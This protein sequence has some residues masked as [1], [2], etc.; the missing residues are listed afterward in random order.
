MSDFMSAMADVSRRRAA[1]TRH[2]LGE[3]ALSAAAGSARPVVPLDL[4]AEGFDLIAEVKLAS[5]SEGRLAAQGDDSTA[6]LGLSSALVGSG[7]AALS[8]LTEP[9]S[10]GGRLEH[11]EVVARRFPVPAMRKDFLVDPIQVLEARAAGASGVLLIARLLE[12]S[13]LSEMTDLSLSLGMF[14]LVELF[15]E[16]DLEIAS[17][18]FDRDVLVGVNARD[19]STLGVDPE[20]HEEMARALPGHL[21][22][23]AESGLVDP[24]DVRRVAGLGYSLALVGTSL[25]R[26]DDPATLA[27]EM[28][29]AGRE[30]RALRDVS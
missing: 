4:S 15:D 13:L 7:A 1:E 22:L 20:R 29:A 10:F 23:V 19:L 5:P 16:T 28:I 17:T 25:A 3:T 24:G 2:T 26:S 11:L 14:V 21:H 9:S 30:A 12:G 8:V 18:V 6:V 27:G